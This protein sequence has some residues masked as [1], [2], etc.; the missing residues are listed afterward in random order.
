VIRK[1]SNSL[2]SFQGA[3]SLA[4]SLHS[5]LA[6][7]LGRGALPEG[8]LEAPGPPDLALRGSGDAAVGQKEFR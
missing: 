8:A 6:W 1:E 2:M 5:A 3:E 4:L 7:G